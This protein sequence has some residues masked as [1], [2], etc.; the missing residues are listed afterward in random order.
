MSSNRSVRSRSLDSGVTPR[1]LYQVVFPDPGNPI[2]NPTYPLG[3]LAAICSAG[4]VAND[5]GC[6]STTILGSTGTLS[7]ATGT[8]AGSTAAATVSA[9]TAGSA[10]RTGAASGYD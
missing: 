3:D 5:S 10:A 2:A 1:R 7:A 4:G 9:A 8:S 6:V